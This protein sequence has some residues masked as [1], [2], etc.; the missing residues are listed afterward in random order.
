MVSR[1]FAEHTEILDAISSADAEAA[2]QLMRKHLLGSRDR[3]FLP[4][5]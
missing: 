5:D 3:L 2:R 4:R 1:V